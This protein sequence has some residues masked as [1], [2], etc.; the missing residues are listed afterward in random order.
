MLMH[1]AAYIYKKCSYDTIRLTCCYFV[2]ILPF[3]YYCL[4]PKS[5]LT[6]FS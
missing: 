3:L 2:P 1:Q 6:A 4:V 5:V